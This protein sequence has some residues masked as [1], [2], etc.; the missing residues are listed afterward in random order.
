MD[1]NKHLPDVPT[2][3][4]VLANGVSLGKM[5]AILLQK[6]EELTLYILQLNKEVKQLKAEK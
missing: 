1:N 5:N 6:V 3:K 4:E 2:E